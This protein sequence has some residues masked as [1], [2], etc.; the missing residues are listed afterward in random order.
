MQMPLVRIAQNATNTP[1]LYRNPLLLLNIL[2]IPSPFSLPLS[3][4]L[5]LMLP[6]HSLPPPFPPVPRSIL[7]PFHPSS[8]LSS[9]SPFS[10]SSLRSLS[11]LRALNWLFASSACNSSTLCN[12]RSIFSRP[13]A[14]SSVSWLA[15]LSRRASCDWRSRT[16]RSTLRT[17][18]RDAECVLS[19]VSS[20]CSSYFTERLSA[21]FGRIPDNLIFLPHALYC[22]KTAHLG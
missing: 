11:A 6:P 21:I 2:L 20:W 10:L 14:T 4:W 22:S 7:S 12:R 5:P 1:H 9:L 8:S 15:I 18:R 16:V 13:L 3:P 17:E 19:C